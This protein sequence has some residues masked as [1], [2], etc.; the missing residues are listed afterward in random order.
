MSLAQFRAVDDTH[1]TLQ[2]P[3]KAADMEN[4]MAERAEAYEIV[5]SIIT[6]LGIKMMHFKT[7]GLGVCRCGKMQ[8]AALAGIGIP[9]KNALA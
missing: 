9:R 7:T 8:A 4:A 1:A 3:G 5:L 2:A 6:W